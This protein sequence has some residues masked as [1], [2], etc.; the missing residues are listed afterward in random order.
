MNTRSRLARLEKRIGS[1][2]ALAR[3]SPDAMRR[4]EIARQRLPDCTDP[5]EAL[6]LI[7]GLP[8]EVYSTLLRIVPDALLTHMHDL[9]VI[10][11]CEHGRIDGY[12]PAELRAMSSDE[13]L[14]LHRTTLRYGE[15]TSPR[16]KRR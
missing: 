2:P 7:R 12:T 14:E 5:E 8:S 3:S 6:S 10:T 15:R 11:E 4:A 1:D 9:A 16:R 13:L